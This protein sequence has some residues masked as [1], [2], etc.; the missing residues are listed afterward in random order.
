[1]YEQ[2]TV[3]RLA[4]E[5]DDGGRER[6]TVLECVGEIHQRLVLQPLSLDSESHARMSMK[7]SQ[8]YKKESK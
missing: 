2:Q 6:D 1:V 8:K 5:E 3:H 7:I 4:G